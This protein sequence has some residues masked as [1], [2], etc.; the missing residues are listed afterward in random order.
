MKVASCKE[1]ILLKICY[2]ICV[3]SLSDFHKY[4]VF[5]SVSLSLFVSAVIYAILHR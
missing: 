4:D 3:F 2:E 5:F 1:G